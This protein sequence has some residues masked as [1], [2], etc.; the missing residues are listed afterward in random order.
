MPIKKPRVAGKKAKAPKKAEASIAG[1]RRLQIDAAIIT[2]AAKPER[3]RE[4]E[5]LGSP[6][7]KNTAAEP[8]MVPIKGIKIPFS[9]SNCKKSPHISKKLSYSVIL[10]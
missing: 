2:P 10:Y 5:P 9:I 1:I 7:K 6:F 8:I 3:N 4:R